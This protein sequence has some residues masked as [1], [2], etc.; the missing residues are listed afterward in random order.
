MI[1]LSLRSSIIHHLVH[2]RPILLLLGAFFFVGQFSQ[3][4]PTFRYHEVQLICVG[5]RDSQRGKNKL[6]LEPPKRQTR[7]QNAGWLPKRKVCFIWIFLKIGG[8]P[9]KMDGLKIMENLIKMDDLGGVFPIFGNTHLRERMFLVWWTWGRGLPKF[10]VHH[11][12]RTSFIPLVCKQRIQNSS[13]DCSQNCFFAKNFPK[14]ASDLRSQIR[15]VIPPHL[16][17][18]FRVRGMFRGNFQGPLQSGILIL[19]VLLELIVTIRKVSW[20]VSPTI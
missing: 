6:T 10:N 14:I 3:Q 12:S 2:C 8:K 17:W 19:D 5:R 4:K 7:S 13:Q 9:T 15:S 16:W 20:V 1:F 18:F 11:L